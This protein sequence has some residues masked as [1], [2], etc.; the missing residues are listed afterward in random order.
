[1]QNFNTTLAA[2]GT[3]AKGVKVQYLCNIVHGEA[4]F[5]FDLLSSD[6]EGTNPLTVENIILWLASYFFL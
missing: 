6:V 4:L 1:M 3:L 2:S 5:Q